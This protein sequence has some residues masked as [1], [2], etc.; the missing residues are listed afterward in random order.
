MKKS[1]SRGLLIFLFITN[2]IFV[3]TTVLYKTKIDKQVF[4]VYSFE[5]EGSDI[6]ISNG[7]V[8]ISPNKHIVNGGEI[9]YIG[10]SQEKLQSYSKTIY[11]DKQVEKEVV[12][13]DSVSFAGNTQITI[14]GEFLLNKGV[15][16]ISSGKLFSKDEI[17]IIKDNLYFSLDYETVDGQRENSTVKLKVTEFNMDEIK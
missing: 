12:L 16:E 4:K 14:P 1:L 6:R 11:L 5:G 2:V 17:N 9:R 3:A 7:I 8:I 10:D 13:S 15:G